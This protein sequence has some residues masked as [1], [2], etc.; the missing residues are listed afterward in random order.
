MRYLAIAIIGFYRKF[1]SPLKG[2]P[3][4]RFYPTCSLYAI[5][6]L[7]D[8]GLIRGGIMTVGRLMRC[9]PFCPGGYDFPPPH[10]ARPNRIHIERIQTQTLPFVPS[11][12]ASRHSSAPTRT[13]HT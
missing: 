2:K 7:R 10:I 6:V 11:E 1:I 13:V 4:C 12:N 5:R 8:W 9:Q 3:T